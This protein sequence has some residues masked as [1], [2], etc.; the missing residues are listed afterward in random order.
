MIFI[1]WCINAKPEAMQLLV[2][3][4]QKKLFGPQKTQRISEILIQ[5]TS[6]VIQYTVHAKT[7]A[8]SGKDCK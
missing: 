1:L 8:Q 4:S 2:Q 5:Q 7:A 6:K 3:R